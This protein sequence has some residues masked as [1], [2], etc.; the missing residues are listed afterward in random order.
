M[1]NKRNILIDRII[2]RYKLYTLPDT[3]R[4]PYNNGKEYFTVSQRLAYKKVFKDDL[5]FII[6]LEILFKKQLLPHSI[7]L[8]YYSVTR[9]TL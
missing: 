9:G 7:N 8:Y 5:R 4:N 1:E 3:Q 2:D 6:L